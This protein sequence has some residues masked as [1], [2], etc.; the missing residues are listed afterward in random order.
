MDVKTW[1]YDSTK[2][3]GVSEGNFSILGNDAIGHC[4]KEVRVHMCILPW[5]GGGGMETTTRY[6]NLMTQ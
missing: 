6:G 4:K 5:L 3:Q 2:I 1:V